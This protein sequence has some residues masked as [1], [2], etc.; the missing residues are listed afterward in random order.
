[1]SALALILDVASSPD[2]YVAIWRDGEIFIEP[3]A[4]AELMGYG[5]VENH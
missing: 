5:P 4:R 2:D 3:A 1:M